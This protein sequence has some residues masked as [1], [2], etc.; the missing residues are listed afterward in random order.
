MSNK[1]NQIEQLLSMSV[2]PASNI[3]KP[4]K[5]IGEGNML[6]GVKKIYT[7]ALEEGKK[8]GFTKGK[9]IGMVKGSL[10][11]IGISSVLYFIPRSV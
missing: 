2:A 4:L 9:K 7:Y 10:I 8:I 5:T 11:T 3:T 1:D 6:V